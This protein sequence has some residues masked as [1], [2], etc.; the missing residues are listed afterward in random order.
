MSI[1]NLT[2][3]IQEP[4]FSESEDNLYISISNTNEFQTSTYLNVDGDLKNQCSISDEIV[5]NF[6]SVECKPNVPNWDLCEI[7]SE[8]LIKDCTSLIQKLKFIWSQIGFNSSTNEKKISIL[9]QSLKK[10]LTNFVNKEN[11]IYELYSKQV[12]EYQIQIESALN[13]MAIYLSEDDLQNMMSEEDNKWIER[14]CLVEQLSYLK[15]IKNNL[16][17]HRDQYLSQ[18]NTCKEQLK[19]ISCSLGEDPIELYPS[20]M[21]E[22]LLTNEQLQKVKKLIL[23]KQNELNE[24]KQICSD[25]AEKV[26]KLSKTIPSKVD[27]CYLIFD[28]IEESYFPP[29]MIF[30]NQVQKEL[31]E[32]L[33]RLLESLDPIWIHLNDACLRMDKIY[34]LFE[35][36]SSAKHRYYDQIKNLIKNGKDSLYSEQ[37]L[38]D[39][40]SPTLQDVCSQL[41]CE[42][43]HYQE[44]KG[45]RIVELIDNVRQ[46]YVNLLDKCLVNEEIRH[47]N[48]QFAFLN[49]DSDLSDELLRQH[50]IEF[51]KL[52][53]YYCKYEDF[54]VLVNKWRELTYQ[55]ANCDQQLHQMNYKDRGGIFLQTLQKQSS[56][57]NKL[58]QTTKKILCWWQKNK[59]LIAN[60]E[61]QMPFDKYQVR[62]EDVI[63]D[64]QL[65]CQE[66]RK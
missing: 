7:F 2:S 52:K 40:T 62:F 57:K 17:N 36:D 20:M 9:R 55:L 25:L 53:F 16:V 26:C 31:S 15:K 10:T 22:K 28:K 47:N 60:N 56:F 63:E 58:K 34:D 11:D 45:K 23:V 30:S 32:H 6:D 38:M 49:T 66:I 27:C 41:E 48:P 33:E 42:Y 5:E 51:D 8:Q 12:K 61:D 39:V 21:N 4:N 18:V 59:L 35:L 1:N 37:W 64:L 19:Q 65:N 43:S 13:D 50:E 54:F 29:E 14:K 44:L 3:R 46:K 24:R